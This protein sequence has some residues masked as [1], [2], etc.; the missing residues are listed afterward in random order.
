MAIWNELACLRR[1]NPNGQKIHEKM[2]DISDHLRNEN[3]NNIW[4]CVTPEIDII[5]IK[6]Q[7]ITNRGQ[8][9]W[10]KNI[11]S[12]LLRMKT[13]TTNMKNS[14]ETLEITKTSNSISPRYFFLLCIFPVEL[15]GLF[16]S[17]VCIQ[18]LIEAEFTIPNLGSSPYTQQQINGKYGIYV[19]TVTLW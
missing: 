19:I 12:L 16:N 3:L 11:S 17:D 6:N 4:D 13:D 8:A 1:Q 5:K 10:K 15:N 9:V 14:M 18:M 7:C 2:H